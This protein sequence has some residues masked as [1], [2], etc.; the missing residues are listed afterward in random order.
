MSRSGMS[1]NTSRRAAR[2]PRFANVMSFSAYYGR[3]IFA[4][5]SVV[6]IASFTN[7]CFASVES[8]SF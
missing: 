3:S 6:L 1:F 7:S 4:L 5:A 8:S 2:S